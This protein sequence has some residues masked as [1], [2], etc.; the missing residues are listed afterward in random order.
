MRF[1]G[2]E[3]AVVYDWDFLRP[4]KE[5]VI[6]GIAASNFTSTWHVEEPNPSSPIETRL[7]VEDYERAREVPFSAEERRAIA[8]AAI[9]AIPYIRARCEHA[10]DVEGRHL[11]GSFREA[12]PVHA[13]AYFRAG[14]LG[15]V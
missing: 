15:E 1:E 7:F 13:G 8:G 5:V 12:L 2:A 9:Y 4:E 11:D 14:A 10:L 3:V 6:V